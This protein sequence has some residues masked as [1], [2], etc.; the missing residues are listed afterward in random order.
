[1]QTTCYWNAEEEILMKQNFEKIVDAPMTRKQK[2]TKQKFMKWIRL[3]P[4]ETTQDFQVEQ[5]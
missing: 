3:Q 4:V 5:Q 2:R 1:M